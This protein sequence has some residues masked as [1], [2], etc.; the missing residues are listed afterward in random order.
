MR[1]RKPTWIPVVAGIIKRENQVLLGL[2]PE[3]KSLPG[4]WE[5][6]GG[7]IEFG[8]SPEQALNRELKEELDIDAEI[9]ELKL[10]TSHNYGDVGVLILFFE[11]VYWKGQP[12]AVHHSDIKW[13]PVC[14]LRDTD[15][16]EANRRVL[17]KIED[18]FK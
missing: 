2:R 13:T 8:E 1:K 18:L 9:G 5:F 17:D 12:K 6:P 7:K 11:V 16:P 4:L 14:D 3:N 15:L 10:A